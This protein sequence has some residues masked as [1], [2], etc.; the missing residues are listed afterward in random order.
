VNATGTLGIVQS[1]LALSVWASWLV[2][3]AVQVPRYRRS[4]GERRQQ[5]NGFIAAP[6]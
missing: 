5:F 4:A 6:P 3:L 1:L 2:W